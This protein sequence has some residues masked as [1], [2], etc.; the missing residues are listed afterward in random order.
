MNPVAGKIVTRS[1]GSWT[2]LSRVKYH[3]GGL[4]KTDLLQTLRSQAIRLNAFAER[5]FASELMTTSPVEY[6]LTF[7]NLAVRDLGCD[8]GATCHELYF[9]AK[10]QGYRLCPLE[11]GP[12]LRL[13]YRDQTDG[14]PSAP[15]RQHRAPPGS[16]TI[17]SEPLTDDEDFPKGFYLRRIGGELWLRGFVCGP[18]HVY[19]PDDHFI[20]VS[21]HSAGS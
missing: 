13:Q 4:S 2:R 20:F 17:A 10:E 9:R 19:D 21:E 12:F 5:I 14:D 15:M 3:V 6:Q 18:D 7:V 11:V 8:Q 16:L 1:S